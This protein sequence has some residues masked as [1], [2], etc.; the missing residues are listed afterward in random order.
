MLKPIQYSLDVIR[1]EA[2]Q[3]V[4][5]GVLDRRQ[6]IYALCKYLPARE[7]GDIERELE[8]N[9]FLLRDSI[10]DLLGHEDWCED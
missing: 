5:K 6:P 3:L 4:C 9:D 2:R 10:L 7:W 8:R 1:E